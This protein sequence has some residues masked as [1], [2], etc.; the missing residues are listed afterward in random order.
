MRICK[1]KNNADSPVMFMID[2]FCNSWVDSNRNG[3]MDLGEDFGAG[4]YNENS[5]IKYHGRNMNCL[6]QYPKRKRF[7]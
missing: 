7:Q 6:K 1:W 3:E 4:M 2:D 5:S